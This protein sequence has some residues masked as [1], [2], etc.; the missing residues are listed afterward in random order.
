G[1]PHRARAA[2][3]RPYCAAGADCAMVTW[4]VIRAEISGRACRMPLRGV[5]VLVVE[6]DADSR[7]TTHRI[8]EQLGGRVVTA[9][10]GERGLE[11]ILS[12]VPDLVLVDLIMPVM[13]GYEFVRRLRSDP[14][15]RRVRLVALTGL[16]EEP[17]VLK[18]WSLGF[19]GH[20]TKPVS[21]E[22]LDLLL[23]RFT[24]RH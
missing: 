24:G 5:T 13:D 19:D 18:S 12:H 7:E 8:L 20:L 4:W 6:D 21:M 2:A 22:G 10:N 16:R 3:A 23:S 11:A 15:Y 1:P 9:E 14:R 17:S